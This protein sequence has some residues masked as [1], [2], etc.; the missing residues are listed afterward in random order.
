MRLLSLAP[1]FCGSL[2]AGGGRAGG[3]EAGKEAGKEGWREGDAG[4]AGGE[5]HTCRRG[6][7]G[8]E[9]EAPGVPSRGPRRQLQDRCGHSWRRHPAPRPQ[10]H[11][12]SPGKRRP[13]RGRCAHSW[14]DPPPPPRSW[15]QSFPP[16]ADVPQVVAAAPEP[17]V[18]VGAPRPGAGWQRGW[19]HR[20]TGKEGSRPQWGRGWRRQEQQLKPGWA[21]PP[22]AGLQRPAG[23]R[24]GSLSTKPALIEAGQG[25]KRSKGN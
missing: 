21:F 14:T 20:A 22:M 12:P 9:E 19:T 8:E 7:R 5:G 6:G 15:R 11:R 10:P 25:C 1:P 16:R 23:N 13:R 24:S 3:R 17:G 4:G 18:V 2:H